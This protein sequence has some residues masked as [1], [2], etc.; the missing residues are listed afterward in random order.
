MYFTHVILLFGL[1]TQNEEWYQ[2]RT[3]TP[4]TSYVILFYFIL[5]LNIKRPKIPSSFLFLF[6]KFLYY[7]SL[8]E[9]T[10]KKKKKII[11]IFFSSSRN[12]WQSGNRK[13]KHITNMTEEIHPLNNLLA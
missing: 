2:R 11:V 7:T 3:Q 1:G 10:Q 5:F 4:D 9:L 13:L 8:S 12:K 6:F